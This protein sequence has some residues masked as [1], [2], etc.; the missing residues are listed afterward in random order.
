MNQTS[1][2]IQRWP[3]QNTPRVPRR[4]LLGRMIQMIFRPIRRVCPAFWEWYNKNRFK[5]TLS[6]I[7]VNFRETFRRAD[8][9][10]L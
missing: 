2:A 7:R 8:S 5:G 9:V 1:M 6:H 4:L 10:Y 3:C